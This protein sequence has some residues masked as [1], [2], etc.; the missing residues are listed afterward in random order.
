MGQKG[1]KIGSHTTTVDPYPGSR[2]VLWSHYLPEQQSS[3][4]WMLGQWVSA[5]T[6]F[7][8]ISGHW[9][10]S[11][12]I[13]THHNKGGQRGCYW[14]FSKQRSRVLL[15]TL[16]CIGQ[17]AQQIIKWSKS[18]CWD[19][20]YPTLRVHTGFLGSAGRLLL[21][22]WLPWHAVLSH[23]SHVQLCNPMDYRL[24]GC[25]GHGTLHVRI[26]EWVVVP[27]SRGSSRPRAWTHVSWG[28]CIVGSFFMA[29]LLLIF[30]YNCNLS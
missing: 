12:D 5:R 7:A 28:S 14:H 21:A 29:E 13:F 22:D 17:I 25:S 18:Q 9:V 23:F 8:P 3:N 30:N 4:W 2:L 19:W 11:G 26:L 27:P 6:H 1:R 20:K 16:Q 15:K 10:I 24:P